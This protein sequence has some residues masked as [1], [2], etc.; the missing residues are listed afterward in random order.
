MEKPAAA[1]L[2]D[3]SQ[4][5]KKIKGE[6]RHRPPQT[7]QTHPTQKRQRTCE[8]T[9]RKQPG[10]TSHGDRRIPQ[11]GHANR[12]PNCQASKSKILMLALK[13]KQGHRQV[14]TT[15]D[16]ILE[17]RLRSQSRK[18]KAADETVSK[19][20][21]TCG[22]ENKVAKPDLLDVFL[23]YIEQHDSPLGLRLTGNLIPLPTPSIPAPQKNKDHSTS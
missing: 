7:R 12:V 22:S 18:T 2:A 9:K 1:N 14:K 6:R 10:S 4:G 16:F 13:L 3:P 21:Q 23:L 20:L 5:S 8:M 19:L 11:E 15:V 17:V